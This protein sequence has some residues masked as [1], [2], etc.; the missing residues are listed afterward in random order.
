MQSEY[1]GGWTE[2]RTYVYW[3]YRLGDI[4]AILSKDLYSYEY[5]LKQ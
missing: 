2:C 3:M 1:R 4:M 5:R